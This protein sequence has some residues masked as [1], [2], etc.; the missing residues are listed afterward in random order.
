MFAYCVVSALVFSLLIL[1]PKT[2]RY[3]MLNGNKSGAGVVLVNLG[4]PEETEQEKVEICAALATHHS[5]KLFSFGA[6]LI[7]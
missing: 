2:P 6:F 5:G 3:L 1:V 7:L 4:A